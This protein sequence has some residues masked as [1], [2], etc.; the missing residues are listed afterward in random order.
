MTV[1]IFVLAFASLPF[2]G[3]SLL[4]QNV[5]RKIT[6]IGSKNDRQSVPTTWQHLSK[7]HPNSPMLI[8][9]SHGCTSLTSFQVFGLVK[10]GVTGLQKLGIFPGQCIS[11]FAENSY[12][13]FLMDQ[14]IMELGC[15]NAVRGVRAPVEELKH[16][17]QN[18]QSTAVVVESFD[19]LQKFVDAIQQSMLPWPKLF[20]IL[21][22]ESMDGSRI[23]SQLK[24]AP[25]PHVHVIAFDDLLV[26]APNDP[27]VFNHIVPPIWKGL[28]TSASIV[29]T[30]GTTALPKGVLLTHG[31]FVYQVTSLVLT[32]PPGHP[33]HC[34]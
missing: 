3:H 16:I 32:V 27:G 28:E 11:M 23:R 2:W 24:Q 25:P 13:W 10:A 18:S 20:I 33:L 21:H 4:G 31:N 6:S 34:A 12:K 1:N 15:H 14:M 26:G 8:D 5:L 7:S 22:A 19:L 17:F 30:S 29:Y 9:P